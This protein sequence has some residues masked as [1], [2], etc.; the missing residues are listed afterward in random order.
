MTIDLKSWLEAYS[1]V[2]KEWM[3]QEKKN[4]PVPT[5][6]AGAYM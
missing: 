5:K 1:S 3:L 2:S 6:T 4:V